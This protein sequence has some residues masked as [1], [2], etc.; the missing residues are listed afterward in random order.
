MM[1][2]VHAGEPEPQTQ[3]GDEEEEGEVTTL[4]RV[5]RTGEVLQAMGT[6]RAFLELTKSEPTTFYAMENTTEVS[7][8][9]CQAMSICDYFS[10]PS[11]EYW[12]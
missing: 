5:P 2:S 4:A 8:N 9:H 7:F 11:P 3:S 6:L 12:L 10:L 1:K